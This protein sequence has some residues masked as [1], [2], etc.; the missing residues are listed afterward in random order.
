MIVFEK[1]S[2][3]KCGACEGVCPSAAIEVGDHI[4]YCDTCNEEPKCASVCKNGAL[5]VDDIAIDE[6]GNTQVRII[7]NKSKCDKCGDCVD[8]CPKDILKATDDEKLPI[9]GFC[10]MCQQCVNICPVD[11]IGVPGV[12]VPTLRV[13]EPEGKIY[14]DSCKGC[15]VCVD[16]CPAGAITLPSCGEDV[17]VDE[18]ACIS[19]GICAQTCPWDAIFVSGDANPAKRAKEIKEFDLDSEA[20]IGCNSCIE[21]CPGDFIK[22]KS[23][24][25]VDLPDVCAAC[26]LCKNVCPVDAITLDVERGDAKASATE[27]IVFNEETC[28]FD[29]GCALKCPTEAIRVVTARGMELPSK[30]KDAGEQSFAMCVRCGACTSVCENDALKLDYVDKEIDGEVVERARIIFNPSKCDSCGVCIN[31]CP[32]DML[33]EAYKVNLPIAGFCTLCEKCL[34]KCTPGSLSLQ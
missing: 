5:Q 11:A 7:F 10:V 23:D 4:V 25:T 8:A 9:K 18:A 15:G 29:G 34:E 22:A 17:V 24:L 31:A 14:V 26:G 13:V 20:C 16:E 19:C 21:V 30:N 12:K 6:E 3:I 32:Y 1:D 33:H 2:C 28:L 27:G